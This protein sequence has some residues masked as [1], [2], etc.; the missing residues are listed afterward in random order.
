MMFRADAWNNSCCRELCNENY[1]LRCQ[2]RPNE[3]LGTTTRDGNNERDGHHHLSLLGS[4]RTSRWQPDLWA[5]GSP[6]VQEVNTAVNQM[7]QVTQQN[8]AMVEETAAAT[9]KLSSEA[10]SLGRLVAQFKLREGS[11]RAVT[12][13][14]RQVS[15]P[16]V[17]R[18]TA[19]VARAVGAA[20]GVDRAWSEF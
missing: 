19:R 20:N 9:H 4:T 18:L 15:E 16:T 7:D 11:I 12:H 14:D 5:A 17:H 1:K 13:Q 8:A 10:D 6:T 2:G 3:A